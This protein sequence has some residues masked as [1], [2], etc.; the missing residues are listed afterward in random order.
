M[1]C[2]S[3]WW[4]LIYKYKNKPARRE[5]ATKAPLLGAKGASPCELI[6]LQSLFELGRRRLH[7]RHW[8][9]LEDCSFTLRLYSVRFVLL[10]RA[11]DDEPSTIDTLMH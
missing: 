1:S 9:Y 6:Q 8:V 3:R 10:E 2:P 4:V 11:C 7:E 5:E